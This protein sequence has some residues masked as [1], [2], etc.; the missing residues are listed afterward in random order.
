VLV[1]FFGAQ[2]SHGEHPLPP[3]PGDEADEP[4]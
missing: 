3:R 1:G 2:L 4:A